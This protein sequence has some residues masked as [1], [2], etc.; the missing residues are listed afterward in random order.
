LIKKAL[1]DISKP[2]KSELEEFEKLFKKSMKSNVG[3]VDLIAKYIIRQK[4]KKI[5]PLLVLLSAKL[6]GGITDRSYRGAVLVELLHTATLIHDDVVDNA[7]KRRGFWSINK[8][9][10][11]KA[12]VLMGDYMLSRGLMIAVE[13]KDFDFLGVIT[14]AVKRMSEGE[15]LQI[16]KTRKLDIDEET[17]FKVISDKTASLLETCCQIGSMSATDNIE[18]H[19]AMKTFGES[20]GMAFQIRDDILDY[21]GSTKIIGKPVGGDIQEKKIT[22]PLIYSLKQVPDGKAD[23]ILKLIKNNN[24][25]QN[26][27][28]IIEFVR[29]NNGIDYALKTAHG[30]SLKAKETLKIF[31]DS[32]SKIALE[33]LVDFVIDRKN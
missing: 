28:E 18:F 3:L 8:V 21:E 10:K 26:T 29:K 15:L 7:D 20:I 2:I 19:E 24:S 9:F 22:L 11:N 25:K 13:G 23:R 14:N 12:A 5:R 4:G 6:S 27:R 31:P 32:P 16:Q 1:T 30:Y 17:Y 33:G